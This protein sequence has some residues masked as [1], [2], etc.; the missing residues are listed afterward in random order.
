MCVYIYIYT[1]IHIYIYIYIYREREREILFEARL[2]EGEVRLA[3]A[4]R[5]SA[6]GA[7]PMRE[8]LTPN[9]TNNT[10]ETIQA[11]NTHTTTPP[12]RQLITLCETRHAPEAKQTDA[13]G[14]GESPG[15]ALRA[16]V[17][18]CVYIYIYISL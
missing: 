9:K 12:N 4:E 2:R 13:D 1:H 18:V 11:T 14:C 5:S 8:H 16:L 7:P 10:K 3:R 17:C 15:P 6:S